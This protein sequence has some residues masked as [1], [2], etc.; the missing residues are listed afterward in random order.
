LEPFFAPSFTSPPPVVN[1]P[2]VKRVVNTRQRGISGTLAESAECISQFCH[3]PGAQP[4]DYP[5]RLRDV[6]E[7]P[8]LNS[9]GFLDFVRSLP[10]DYPQYPQIPRSEAKP[11][12]KSAA[13]RSSVHCN[14]AY[15]ALAAFR[16]GMSESA[17][18]PAISLG[19]FQI[20]RV[21]FLGTQITQEEGRVI[22]AESSGARPLHSPTIKSLYLRRSFKS[23]RYS[24][25]V[26][27]TLIRLKAG[28][29]VNALL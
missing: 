5:M 14:F 10:E 20:Q 3:F 27:P 11:S 7:C 4:C 15:S 21:D 25:R 2:T 17:S 8:S 26:R 1:E 23:S 6:R 29:S 19:K 9:Q 16:V 24:E 22:R 12:Q 28:C 13:R 18:F